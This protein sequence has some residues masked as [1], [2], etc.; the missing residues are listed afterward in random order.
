MKIKVSCLP[1]V[2]VIVHIAAVHWY[3][4][5]NGYV[6]E[7][8]PVLA[9]IYQSGHMQLMRNQH[10]D[11][12]RVILFVFIFHFIRIT[13]CFLFQEPIILDTGMYVTNCRWNHDGSVLAVTGST[14]LIGETKETNVIQFFSPFGEVITRE[15]DFIPNS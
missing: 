10:D 3:N 9:I 1:A 6:E 5:R 15:F 7:N 14:V 8:C 4:G 2:H 11:S 12:K 13:L